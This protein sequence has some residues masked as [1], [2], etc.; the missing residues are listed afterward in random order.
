MDNLIIVMI[1][2]LTGFTGIAIGALFGAYLS[3]R[4]T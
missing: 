4:T 3:R 2:G 1:V